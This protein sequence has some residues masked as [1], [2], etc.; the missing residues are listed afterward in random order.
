MTLTLKFPEQLNAELEV[1]P[2]TRHYTSTSEFLKDVLKTIL[3]A[4]NDLKVSVAIELY[5]KD[6][7]LGRVAE[8]ADLDYEVMKEILVKSGIEMRRGAETVEE[9]ETGARMLREFRM[10]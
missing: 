7:S 1:I 4:R 3:A 10:K 8:I 5:K 9:L 2:K 6:H